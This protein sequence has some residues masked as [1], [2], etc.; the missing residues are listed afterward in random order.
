L[1][2]KTGAGALAVKYLK[3]LQDNQLDLAT[4]YKNFD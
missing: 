2:D 4:F 3:N 1:G